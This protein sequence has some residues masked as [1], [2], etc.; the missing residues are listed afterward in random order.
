M[1]ALFQFSRFAFI[2]TLAVLCLGDKTLAAGR[3]IAVIASVS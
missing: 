3:E 2:P 1:P